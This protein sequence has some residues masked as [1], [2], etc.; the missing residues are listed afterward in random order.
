MAISNSKYGKLL[1]IHIGNKLTY[2][3]HVKSLYK[4]VNQKLNAFATIAYSLKFEQRNLK[5]HE[6]GYGATCPVN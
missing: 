3:P 1:G 2:K 5:L 6:I 4:K